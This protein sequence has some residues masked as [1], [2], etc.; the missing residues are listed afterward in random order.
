M[1]NRAICGAYFF[2]N[3]ELFRMM[4]EKYFATCQYKEYF[5]SGLYNELCKAGKKVLA[6]EADFHL[7]FGTPAEYGEAKASPYLDVY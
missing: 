6:F 4:S 3:A 5:V 2:A 7:P 1:S